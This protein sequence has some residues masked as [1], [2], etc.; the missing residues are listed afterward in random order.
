MPDRSYITYLYGILLGLVFFLLVRSLFSVYYTPGVNTLYNSPVTQQL[1]PN[2]MKKLFPT[3]GYNK[4][5]MYD[6]Q[7]F[8]FGQGSFWPES[9][10]G[11]QPTIYASGGASPEGGMRKTLPIP[12]EV[13]VGW[14]STSPRVERSIHL[15]VYD[16]RLQHV[17]YVTPV[18]HWD[19]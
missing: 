17:E 13:E 8:T 5:G 10:K 12:K 1:F 19:E 18:G 15:P 2:A 9:G 7:A 11:Y 3:W 6:G 16:D 4:A 14:W